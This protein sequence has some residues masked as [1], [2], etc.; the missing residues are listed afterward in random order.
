MDVFVIN[1]IPKSLSGETNQDSEPSLAVNPANPLQAAATAF[2][3][4]PL[5]GPLAP[6]YVTSDG[7]R[8][9]ALNLIVPGAG[10]GLAGFGIPYTPTADITLRFGGKSNVLYAGTIRGDTVVL[11]IL[12]TANFLSPTVMTVLETR[13]PFLQ[14]DQPWV[15]ATTAEK[16]GGAPDRVYVGNNDFNTLP[17]ATVDLSL[18]AATGP[19]PAGFGPSA[20]TA[21]IP[22][23][24]QNGPSIRPVMHQ[25]GTVYVAF[26]NWTTPASIPFTADVVVCRD[27]NWG[28]G[29]PPFSDL[30]D[31]DGFAGLRVAP[32][33]QIPWANFSFLGQERVGSHISIAVDPRDSSVVYLAWADFPTGVAP[34]TIHLRRSR[35]RGATWSGDLR[36]IA[37]GINPALAISEKGHVGFLYQTLTN[38]GAT[39]ETHVEISRN[40]FQGQWLTA[41]LAATPS[42]TPVVGPHPYLGDYVYLQAVGKDFY[43]V[44][45]ANN[46]P[47][48]ASFPNGVTY[49]RNAN[50]ATKTLLAVDNVTPVPI[51]IDPFFFKVKVKTGEVATAIADSGNFG[52]VCLGSFADEILTINNPGDGRLKIFN[53]I[54]APADF[55][56][57]SVVAYPLIVRAGDSI[58]IV[59]RFRPLSHGLKAGTVTIIGDDP[60]GPHK[61]AVSGD[62]PAPH[63]SLILADAGTFAKT[64][65]G[66][67]TDE[68]LLLGNTSHCPLTITGIASNAADFVVPEVLAYPLLIAPGG[69]LP[70]PIR[71]A[72]TSIGL[73]SATIEVFSDDPSSPT[74]IDVRGDAPVGKLTVAGST[75]FGGVNACCCADRT[76]S[77]CNTGDCALYV[78]GVHFKRK[79]RHWKLLH[80]PFPAKLAAGSCLAIV[81]Q[82]RANEKCSRPCELVIE[83]DDPVTPVKFVEVLAYTIWDACCKEDCDDCRKGCCDKHS[84]CRQGYPCCDDDDDDEEDR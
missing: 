48:N 79:S 12:R 29:A 81:I 49:Q 13:G 34:Y 1:M 10:S 37:N 68:H 47:D 63:L 26:F 31:P 16:V 6:I 32:G 18:D 55:E 42:N 59:I 35:D 28:Q 57:P 36:L 72:P 8:S 64:C 43:G 51:S 9:W 56:A 7:G 62:C 77:I 52:R 66:S 41:V 73:K 80:N 23:G 53:I 5:S 69:F 67:F 40:G 38:S 54:A 78:T 19:P 61:V 4:D 20:L 82:Y 76:L 11:N 15:Q 39:W 30:M 22:A 74:A 45:S 65:V 58:D 60:S 70:A 44:F 17:T 2:T 27:D 75:N 33:V 3:P 21:R 14:E 84:S 24:G 25:D 83:S 50:F 71:F 46:T